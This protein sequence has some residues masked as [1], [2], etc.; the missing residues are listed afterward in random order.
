MAKVEEVIGCPHAED[1][2][3]PFDDLERE[4][5]ALIL[6]LQAIQP[7]VNSLVLIIGSSSIATEA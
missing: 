6:Y 2:I 3:D 4:K 1:P 5:S 7:Y